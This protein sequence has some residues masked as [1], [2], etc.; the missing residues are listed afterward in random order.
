MTDD[1]Y[2][3]LGNL[4]RAY[5]HQDYEHETDEAGFVDFANT[6]DVEDRKRLITEIGYFISAHQ[7]H[8]LACFNALFRPDLI[9]A[10]DDREIVEWLRS[11]ARAIDPG[12]SAGSQD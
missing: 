3:L 6:H 5:F 11:A 10:E 2:P 8:T 12:Q 9:L 1:D 7:K 4:V